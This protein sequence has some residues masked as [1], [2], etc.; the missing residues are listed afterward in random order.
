VNGTAPASGSRAAKV[1]TTRPSSSP[2][3][4]TCRYGQAKSKDL[5]YWESQK[6]P[7]VTSDFEG[8]R[9]KVTIDGQEQ[10]G[11]I[12]RV[13]WTLVDK[14]TKHYERNQYRNVLHAER[15]VQDKERFAGLKP[16]KA[17]ITVQPEETKEISNLL[18]GIFFEDINY[19]ADGGLYAEL[20][21]NRDF[22]YD[23]SDREGDKNW[24]STHSWKLEGDNATFTINTSDPVHPNYRTPAQKDI[25]RN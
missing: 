10:T 15:P 8:T 16:V 12:N 17:T 5:V 14:L 4:V 21:Q 13:S 6:Y 9:V 19:S 2:R 3:G 22:E 7:Q 11:N 23:P 18:L 20:I 1:K 24:N 25:Y